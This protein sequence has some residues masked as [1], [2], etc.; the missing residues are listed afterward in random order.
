MDNPENMAIYSTQDEEKQN[1]QT[2]Q[3]MFDTTMCKQ[4]QQ[5]LKRHESSYK[6]LEVKTNRTLFLMPK[7]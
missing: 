3:Y 5:T 6:Q 2:T 7:S 1:I 4:T